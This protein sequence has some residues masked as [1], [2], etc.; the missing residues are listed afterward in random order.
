MANKLSESEQEELKALQDER[1]VTEGH[2]SDS[3]R[4]RLSELLSKQKGGDEKTGATTASVGSG[5]AAAGREERAS[6]A[7]SGNITTSRR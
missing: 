2:I 7:S 6:S 4:I 3:R 1:K 5:T